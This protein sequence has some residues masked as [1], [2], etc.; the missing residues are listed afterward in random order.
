MPWL[1][2]CKRYLKGA[3]AAGAVVIALCRPAAPLAW[4]D[5]PGDLPASEIDLTSL[6]I[7]QLMDI[8]VTSVSK[9]GESWF[10]APAAIYVITQEDIRRSGARSI[11][12]ALRMAPGLHVARLD[13]HRWM[14]GSR[15]FSYEFA[16]KLLV[17]IDGRSVYNPTFSGVHWDAQDTLLEDVERIEVIRGPGAALWGANAVNGIINIITKRAEDTQGWLITTGAGDEERGFGAVRYGGKLGDDAYYRVYAKY[18]SRD[19]FVDAGGHDADDD[20]NA[21][22]TGFRIDWT[23]LEDDSFTFQGDI[24]AGEESEAAI[25]PLLSFPFSTEADENLDIG[26]GNLLGR[27]THVFSETS[28]MALQIYYDRTEREWLFATSEERDTVDIDFQHSFALGYRHAILWGLGYRFTGGEAGDM[29]SSSL[30]PP[31]RRDDLFSAFIQDEI[32]LI[33]D[34]VRLTLGS[35]FEHNDYTGFEVQPSARALW[36]PHEN[37]TVWAA[38]SRAVRT[39]SWIE[40][41]ISIIT[42]VEFPPEVLVPTYEVLVPSKDEFGAEEL[43]AYEVGYRVRPTKTLSLDIAVF[44]NN[45]DDLRSF[46]AGVPISTFP[47]MVV[48]MTFDNKMDGSTRGV[49]IAAEWNVTDRWT[50]K[51]GYAFIDMNF[52][53]DSDSSTDP[54]YPDNEE[55]TTP[56]HQF[57]LR[58][59]LDL[60]H[61][62]ELDA[63]IYYVDNLP[64]YEISSYVR[65]DLRLAWHPNENLELSIV[66]QNVFGGHHKEF[67]PDLFTPTSEPERSVYGK[68]TLRF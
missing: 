54:A 27:W 58:S 16:N 37:H 59:L 61:D 6:S 22:R 36:T 55:G 14:I 10:Q 60:P 15:G 33:P 56:Q 65:A 45:Y 67:E 8:E 3:I 52:D 64:T 1:R 30:D 29:T 38:V 68:I 35:K 5:A 47:I 40:H 4:T 17:L 50:L 41:N 19:D 46:E 7:E 43:L 20:W 24:Y 48:P 21:F 57:Q 44:Y 26:G 42:S 11:P 53:L 39:P 18:F 28:E 63:A 66:G 51:S 62:L 2:L 12:E 23:G 9:K 32:T 49:E 25:L 13:S 31:S 34:R